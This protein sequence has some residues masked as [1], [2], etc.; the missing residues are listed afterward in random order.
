MSNN[1]TTS[2]TQPSFSNV[3][4]PQILM[5]NNGVGMQT[6]PLSGAG[7]HQGQNL[8][9][10]FV[11]N[12][13]QPMNTPPFMNAANQ[14]LPLRNNQMHL[15]HMGLVGPLQGQPHAGALGQQNS[16]GSA[17]YNPMFPVQGLAMQNA[18]PIN[19]S[20]LQGQLLAQGI[21][22]MLQQPNLNLSM[23]NGQFCAPY[24]VQNMNQQLPMQVPNPS[25]VVPYSMLP[26]SCP[27]FGF[28]NQVAQPMVPQSSVYSSNSQF[29]LVPGNQ[30]GLQID[31]NEKN[32]VPPNANTNAFV[33]SSPFSSQQ[34]QGNASGPLNPN[35]VHAN[36]SQPSAFTKSHSQD[37]PNSNVK[38]N[39]PKSNWKGSPSKHFKNKPNQGGFQGGFQKSKFH[40]INNGKRRIGFPKEHKGKG[41]N[42][43]K[44]G[45]DAL[46]PKE[47]KQEQERSFSVTYTEQEIQQWRE[48]RKKNHPFSNNIQKKHSERLKDSKVIDREVLQRELTKVLAKQAELGLEVAE[49]P[50]CYLKNSENQGLQSE[51][52]NKFTNK[53]KFQNKFNKK[54]DRKGRFAKK[55]KFADK[56]FSENPS[57]KKRKP[58]LLQKLLSA[59][60]K[61]DKSYLFQVF[62]FM[63]MNSFF[64][65]CPEKPLRYPSVL[66]EENG[67][68]GGGEGKY[69]HTGQDVLK[70]ENESTVQKIVNH[71]NDKGRDSE[72]EDSDD[73]DNDTVI[74]NDPHKEPSSLVE[75]NCDNGEGIE[76]SDEEEGE[77]IE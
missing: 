52:K 21:L 29:G 72:D 53:R 55:Q 7:N 71:N 67:S 51:G 73:D 17:N 61:R 2:R 32:L 68:E 11:P 41:P 77:I 5:Q 1:P 56:D 49:I 16:V 62:R 48:A 14:F 10:P 57:S 60:I 35:S 8:M 45:Q 34:L 54:S 24:H 65:H 37:N 30:V 43:G 69:L 18:A 64:K 19:L 58:T 74:D 26:S 27:M 28:P 40:D 25:Q 12:M 44:A 66:I 3:P 22:N 31:P 23:Q 63:V 75:R 50:S 36:N 13:Q 6:Q 4:K 76:G 33:S 20:Q 15:P 59:D 47:L 38:T 39:V 46:K 70:P 9:T 42:N